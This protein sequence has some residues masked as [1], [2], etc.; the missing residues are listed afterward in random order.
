MWK[1]LKAN[2]LRLNPSFGLS[3]GLAS[4]LNTDSLMLRLPQG[5]NLTAYPPANHLLAALPQQE[6]EQL[7]PHLTLVAWNQ[8]EQL[9]GA[10]DPAI[11]VSF[12]LSGILSHS[13][14]AEDGTHVEVGLVG[15]ESL[16]GTEAILPEGKMIH[17]VM[18]QI[19][20]K[21]LTLAAEPFREAFQR[22]GVFQQITLRSL[23]SMSA[24][25]SQ[26]ALCNRLHTVEQRLGRWLMMV[27]DRI[28][29]DE[30][31]LRQEVIGD[32]L[33]TSR[34][35][36]TVAAGSLRAAGLIEYSRGRI[37]VV[38][39]TGLEKMSCECYKVIQQHLNRLLPGS[40]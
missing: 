27:H 32:M 36:V 10:G 5:S 1:L 24:Q 9:S 38:N 29:G 3:F 21:A 4:V 19:E 16:S 17:T 7:L 26:T 20:G 22:G 8:G 25:T 6:Y 15:C 35:E 40:K 13:L 14:T 30:L 31:K 18:V 2:L 34:S 37:T 23:Q 12:P 11:Y 33:G 39:R 28:Q